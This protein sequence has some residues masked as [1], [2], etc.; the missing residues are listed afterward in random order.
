MRRFMLLFLI[1]AVLLPLAGCKNNA[2]T[3]DGQRVLL[4]NMYA[5]SPLA[6][7][8]KSTV[9]GNQVLIDGD[10]LYLYSSANV[11]LYTFDMAGNY[12]EAL[13]VSPAED[14]SPLQVFP[15][16]GGY[17]QF[18]RRSSDFNTFVLARTDENGE[19]VA[20]TDVE[21]V[22]F[23][24]VL[25]VMGENIYLFSGSTV[26]LYEKNLSVQRTVSL[27]IQASGFRA[28]PDAQG[29]EVA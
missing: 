4:E 24:S 13:S 6:T 1:L 26:L 3:A 20:V 14:C 21:N 11:V 18:G 29:T 17:V 9:S 23:L 5:A 22:D 2:D 12:L 15:Y 7:P 28:I 27:S 25:G 8:E 19:T 10:I 16:D